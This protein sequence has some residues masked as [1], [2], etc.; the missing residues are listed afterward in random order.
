MVST[1][2]EVYIVT[3]DYFDDFKRKYIYINRYIGVANSSIMAKAIIDK[4]ATDYI[5][6]AISEDDNGLDFSTLKK[7]R[8][9]SFVLYLGGESLTFNIR[10]VSTMNSPTV[11]P[12]TWAEDSD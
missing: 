5:E 4:V 6:V 9:G 10:K 8:G 7:R 11:K 3:S 2:N 1:A 12:L